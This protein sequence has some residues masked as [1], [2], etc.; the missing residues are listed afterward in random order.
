[1]YQHILTRDYELWPTGCKQT[2]VASVADKDTREDILLLAGL[3]AAKLRSNSRKK[4]P[5]PLRSVTSALSIS[6]LQALC[7][8]LE[9]RCKF[10]YEG[11]KLPR[12]ARTPLSKVLRER[13]ARMCGAAEKSQ[14]SPAARFFFKNRQKLGHNDCIAITAAGILAQGGLVRAEPNHERGSCRQMVLRQRQLFL[15]I[16]GE[17]GSVVPALTPKFRNPD[18]RVTEQIPLCNPRP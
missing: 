18:A 1:M 4:R 8:H 14:G 16:C 5:T 10:S 13:L 7:F 11:L 12:A 9:H 3:G 6:P 2:K 17:P 15:R